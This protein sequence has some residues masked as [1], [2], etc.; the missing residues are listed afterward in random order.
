M[1]PG[2]G[3]L[4][5]RVTRFPER[6]AAGGSLRVPHIGWNQVRFR[7]EGIGASGHPML[8][9]LPAEDCFYFVHSYRAVP[10]D[11]SVVAG[12]TDY[13][14]RFA[15]AVAGDGFFAVQFHPEKSQWAGKRL[16][17]AY[18]RWVLAC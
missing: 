1:T 6:D 8:E 2:L 14:G 3:R 7:G 10:D 11:P 9:S 18:A 16:L 4:P 12:T 5:G 13:G 15:S 17:D